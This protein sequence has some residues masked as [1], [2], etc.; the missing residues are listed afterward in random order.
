M[1]AL[2]GA[3]ASRFATGGASTRR[4]RHDAGAGR[5]LASLLRDLT[6][7]SNDVTLV[8]DDEDRI[9][10]VNDRAV[11]L[12]GYSREELLRMRIRELR[13]PAT[14]GDVEA[15]L[16]EQRKKGQAVFDT[17]FR[18]KDGTFFDGEVSVRVFKAGGKR[19]HQ[20]SIRDVTAFVR[21][22]EALRES[23]AKFRA[24]F[25]GAS[26]GI[27]LLDGAG[28]FL[29]YNR[30]FIDMLGWSAEELGRMVIRD[31]I[32]PDDRAAS[33]A[34]FVEVLANRRDLIV[35]ERRYLR[36]DG[37]C[38][39]GLLR[40]T[41]VR[42]DAGTFLYSVGLVEDITEK[43]ALEAQLLFAD[44]MTSM[45]TLAAGVAHEINNP[46]AFILSNLEYVRDELARLSPPPQGLLVA[47]DETREGADRVR[48]I[49]RDLKTFSRQDDPPAEPVDLRPVVRSALN[50]ANNEIRHR[51]RVAL[52]LGPVPLVRGSAHRLGQVLLNLLINAAQAMEPGQANHNLVRVVTRTGEDGRAVVEVRDTGSGIAPEHVARIFDPFFTTKPVGTG[53]G[54]GLAV[55]HGIVS[56]LGGEIQVET[57]QGK[58]T[59]MR[60]VFPPVAD[61][62]APG[63]G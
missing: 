7:F 19:Y 40:S 54:L 55:C 51:A 41:V 34:D 47:L 44:R 52:E 5:A 9:L 13:D 56:G 8:T 60:V 28:H 39:Q 58:G 3:A 24:A 15:R 36:K 22:Q 20:G 48:E 63:Q 18:R 61:P 32:H 4:K 11:S 16:E 25:Q 14:V 37:R 35:G 31:V 6:R 1:A 33:R 30:A 42:D 23:E 49:V 43:R 53:T 17:R 10:E 12:L 62:V 45:G 27:C 21:A 50:L 57:E 2:A 46:L 59:T 29:E 38:M 26:L